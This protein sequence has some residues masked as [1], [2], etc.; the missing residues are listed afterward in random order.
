MQKLN[1]KVFPSENLPLS[2]SFNNK[3]SK[4]SDRKNAIVKTSKEYGSDST[5]HGISYLVDETRSKGERIFWTVVVC[6]AISFTIY[7]MGTLHMQWQDH[8]VI[9]EL[10]T[11]ALPIEEIEFPAVTICPQGAIKNMSEIVLGQQFMEFVK[12]KR[13]KEKSR[14]KREV[15]PWN[16]TEIKRELTYQDMINNMKEFMREVYPG[17]K[18]KPTKFTRLMWSR[19][20]KKALENAVILHQTDEVECDESHNQNVLQNMN[21]HLNGDFCPETFQM[22]EGNDCIHTSKEEMTYEEADNYCHAQNGA[23]LVGFESYSS[24]DSFQQYLMGGT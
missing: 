23:T 8:P 18:D 22:V 19:D 12:D 24:L 17:A 4:N 5:A 1:K 9:T 6:L 20:P 16:S 3:Q 21:K 14:R 2:E 10:D 7:Q 11:V 15:A 13:K